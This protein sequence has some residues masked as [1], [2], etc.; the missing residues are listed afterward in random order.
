[1]YKSISNNEKDLMRK[2]RDRVRDRERELKVKG[3]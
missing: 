2:E 1:M 3:K